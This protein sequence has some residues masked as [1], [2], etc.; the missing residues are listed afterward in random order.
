MS[1][2][3]HGVSLQQWNS[4]RQGPR[5][6]N[7]QTKEDTSI[8]KLDQG[9]GIKA[10]WVKRLAATSNHLGSIPR[11]YIGRRELILTGYVL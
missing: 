3:G 1:C 7:L 9:D 11:L 5:K 4:I 2:F 8:E 6:Q 10:Q